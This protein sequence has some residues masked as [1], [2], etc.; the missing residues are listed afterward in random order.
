MSA[1]V[2]SHPEFTN[3]SNIIYQHLPTGNGDFMKHFI[4]EVKSSA[5]N[6]ER[7]ETMDQLMIFVSVGN[8]SG[9]FMIEGP[10]KLQLPL[11]QSL[12]LYGLQKVVEKGKISSKSSSWYFERSK[13]D[14]R[15]RTRYPAIH[16]EVILKSVLVLT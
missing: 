5:I 14:E 1:N 9:T 7:I 16:Q 11:V 6:Q 8:E 15:A 2:V 4:R 10:K 3:E 12:Q 13:C